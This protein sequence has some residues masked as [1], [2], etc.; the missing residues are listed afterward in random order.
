MIG[1]IGIILVITGLMVLFL[2]YCKDE[3]NCLGKIEELRD[4]IQSWEAIFG[5]SSLALAA[6]GVVMIVFDMVM[7]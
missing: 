5:T 6:S 3:N 1:I 4:L 7:F 2:V